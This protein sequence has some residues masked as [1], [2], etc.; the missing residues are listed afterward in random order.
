[1]RIS[2]LILAKDINIDSDYNNVLTYTEEQMLELVNSKKQYISENMSFLNAENM[3]EVSVDCSYATARSCNYLAY[4]NP[5]YSNKWFFAFIKEVSYV[6]DKC[7]NIKFQIDEWSTWFDYWDPHQCF[8]IREHT[9]NDTIGSNLQPESLETGEYIIDGGAVNDELKSYSIILCSTVDP[10]EAQPNYGGVYGGIFQ[11]YRMYRYNFN[12]EGITALQNALFNIQ[13]KTGSDNAIVA[14]F[15]ANAKFYSLDGN[16]GGNGGEIPQSRY[17]Q[18]FNWSINKTTTLDGYTPR[19][20]KLLTYPFCYLLMDNGNGGNAK[21]RYEDFKLETN[22][23][24][25]IYGTTS[26]GMST[27]IKPNNYQST[28]GSGISAN[29]PRLPGGKLPTCGWY[30]DVYVNWLTNNA[31]PTAVNLSVDAL[32][33][34]T[35]VGRTIAGDYTGVAQSVSAGVSIFNAMYQKHL[36]EIQP[37]QV[38]G[39]I[40]NGDINFT[41]GLTT[42][43]A[44][45]MSIKSEFARK[46]DDYFTRFGYATNELKVPNIIGRSKFNYLQIGDGEDI[47]YGTAPAIDMEIINNIARRGTCMWHDHSYIGNY[48]NNNIV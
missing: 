31:L 27:F 14:I 28:D 29:L 13:D 30:N 39:N 26:I 37:P 5:A 3:N 41:A 48:D 4:Q 6:S 15:M 38:R 36:A 19:N 21:F 22:M 42:F 33:L 40:S 11:G 44:Y 45:F 7:T 1:M 9:N 23:N 17:P 16:P 32:S 25:T 2:K 20:K 47:G 35:G 46:I 12:D 8:V 18:G 24:F 10:E 34:A 43:T